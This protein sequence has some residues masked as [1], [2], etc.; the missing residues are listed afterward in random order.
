[1]TV[2]FLIRDRQ[3]KGSALQNASRY[4]AAHL[5]SQKIQASVLALGEGD[6]LQP[7]TS[8]DI[9]DVVVI[10]GAGWVTPEVIRMMDP[11]REARYSSRPRRARVP[12]LRAARSFGG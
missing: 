8:H 9:G 3:L 1:M 10:E 5:N 6:T 4:D 7:Y 2:T 12:V 11:S